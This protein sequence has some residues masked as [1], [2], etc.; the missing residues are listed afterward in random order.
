VGLNKALPSIFSPPSEDFTNFP[1]VL[2]PA[3]A[4]RKSCALET[5]A[6][7]APLVLK[8]FE[9]GPL[10]PLGTGTANGFAVLALLK[11]ASTR[12]VLA[13]AFALRDV[14]KAMPPPDAMPPSLS[15]KKRLSSGSSSTAPPAAASS[16]FFSM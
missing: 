2:F 10:T 4:R 16:R 5:L 7:S 1:P 6:S 3:A 15:T 11:M 13:R 8:A 12:R 14:G 9:G